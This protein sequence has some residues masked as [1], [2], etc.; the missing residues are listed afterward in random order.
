M[1]FR[2]QWSGNY[3]KNEIVTVTD[4]VNLEKLPLGKQF[5]FY[6]LPLKI[7]D[8]DGSPIRAVAVL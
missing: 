8:G 3:C 6:G 7:K 4:L 5:M 1:N 2:W